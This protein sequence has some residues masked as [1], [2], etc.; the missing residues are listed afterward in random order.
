[1]KT[2]LLLRVLNG[3]LALILCLGMMSCS[4]EKAP[5]SD[6]NDDPDAS[7]IPDIEPLPDAP[8]DG[9]I[10]GRAPVNGLDSPEG[11]DDSKGGA[12]WDAPV[13]SDEPMEPMTPMLPDSVDGYYGGDVIGG[14]VTGGGNISYQ[15]GM[16]TGAEWR[17]NDNYADFIDK[18][19]AFGEETAQTSSQALGSDYDRAHPRSRDGWCDARQA[20][21]GASACG[22]RPALAGC[23]RCRRRR[24]FVPLS[25]R[26]DRGERADACDRDDG[27]WA[28]D[29]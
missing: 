26:L 22:R 20:G 24:L 14:Y 6:A 3:L 28:G 23:D 13:S 8:Q 16:L 7:H 4:T 25:R 15:A 19:N 27:G 5:E 11:V 18:L 21:D 12:I 9:E 2:N 17:D 1:M 10:G 29:G